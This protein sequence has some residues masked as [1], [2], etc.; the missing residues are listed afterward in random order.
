MF[1]PISAACSVTLYNL[2]HN[3][4]E[5]DLQNLAYFAEYGR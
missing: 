2:M 3:I 4:Q 5:N 1:F